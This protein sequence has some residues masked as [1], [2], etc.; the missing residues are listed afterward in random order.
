MPT[1]DP[2]K[3]YK[4]EEDDIFEIK[5]KQLASLY[6]MINNEIK[7]GC[8]SMQLKVE[9]YNSVMDIFKRGVEEGKILEQEESNEPEDNEEEIKAE[10]DP[11]VRNL[12][13]SN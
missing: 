12:F 4:W 13:P 10:E 6:H 5:G 11:L 1:Y 7:I 3:A 9:A 2:N 8:S